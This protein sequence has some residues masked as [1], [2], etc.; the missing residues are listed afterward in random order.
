MLLENAIQVLPADDASLG[1]VYDLCCV[2]HYPKYEFDGETADIN[3]AVECARLA[4]QDQRSDNMWNYYRLL[5]QTLVTRYDRLQQIEDLQDAEN[6]AKE[7]LSR[8][9]EENHENQAQCRWILG[10][11]TRAMYNRARNTNTLRRALE[12][13]QQASRDIST[14]ISS[15]SLVLND[16]GNAH[17]EFFSHEALPEHLEKA[18]EAYKESLLGLQR[19]YKTNQHYDILMVNAALGSV[20]LRRFT[21]WRAVADIE[22]TIKYYR[23][24]LSRIDEHHPRYAI[25][26]ANLSYALTFRAQIKMNMEDL[27]EAQR[28]AAVVEGPVVLGD[29][30]KTAL[31]TSLGNGF[32]IAFDISGKRVDLVHAVD[33]YAKASS[34]KG[35]SASARATA[36]V[37]AATT[38]TQLAGYLGQR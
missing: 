23:R 24:S 16:L 7:G 33:H 36:M 31:E 38:L 19:L 15:K 4:T 14:D 21:H 8:C 28:L 37:N 20:M 10:K 34:V 6:A 35:A 18:I 22:S 13:F 30:L 29:T 25:R 11:I 5:A 3:R 1:R 12:I 2:V 26:A 27:R 32:K 9:G 17:V